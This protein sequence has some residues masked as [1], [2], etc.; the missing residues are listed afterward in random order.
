LSASHSDRGIYRLKASSRSSIRYPFAASPAT[1][2]V[3]AKNPQGQGFGG[4]LGQDDNEPKD[5]HEGVMKGIVEFGFTIYGPTPPWNYDQFGRATNK[6]DAA[7]N[8]IFVYK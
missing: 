8:P 2:I 4:P 1:H 3:F 7:S 5:L 6:V